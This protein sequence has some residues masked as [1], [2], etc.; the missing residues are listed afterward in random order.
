[1]IDIFSTIRWGAQE[2]LQNNLLWV[3]VIGGGLLFLIFLAIFIWSLT[4]RRRKK[5]NIKQVPSSY[6]PDP[7]LAKTAPDQSPRPSNQAAQTFGIQFVFDTGETRVFETLPISIGRGDDNDLILDDETI[8]NSHASVFY[9]KLAGA[10]CIADYGSLNGI[11]VDDLPTTK[12]VLYDGSRIR[13]GKVQ[14]V[15]RDMGY[16]NS[17]VQ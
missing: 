16:L 9:D 3:A 8:S 11:F 10:I 2:P 1:M 15:F 12:N 4:S 17:A 5:N 13:L 7:S 14:L 6:N